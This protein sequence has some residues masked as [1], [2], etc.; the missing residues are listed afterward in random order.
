MFAVCQASAAVACVTYATE[1]LAHTVM[2][3]LIAAKMASLG[4]KAFLRRVSFN[5]VGGVG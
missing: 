3:Y 4:G 5:A 1:C 2:R